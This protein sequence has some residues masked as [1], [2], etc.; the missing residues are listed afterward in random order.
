M[1]PGLGRMIIVGK[2]PHYFHEEK[3]ELRSSRYSINFNA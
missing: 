2:P 3:N 1:V